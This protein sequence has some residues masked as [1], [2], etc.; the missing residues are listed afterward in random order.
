MVWWS[1]RILLG[2]GEQ[3]RKS[4]GELVRGRSRRFLPPSKA[5]SVEKSELDRRPR[6]MEGGS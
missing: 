3:K 4:R 6:L 2:A 1:G 5:R